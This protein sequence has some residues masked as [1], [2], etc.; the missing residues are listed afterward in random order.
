MPFNKGTEPLLEIFDNT[1]FDAHFE[2]DWMAEIESGL[3]TRLE[4]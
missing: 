2:K 3:R 1:H 4:R